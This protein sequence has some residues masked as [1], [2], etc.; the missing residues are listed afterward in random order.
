MELPGSNIKSVVGIADLRLKRERENDLRF[1]ANLLQ[2]LERENF[3]ERERERERE[4]TKYEKLIGRLE[5]V[6]VQLEALFAEFWTR[7]PLES[8][9]RVVMLKRLVGGIGVRV[10]IGV[11][12]I[13]MRQK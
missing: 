6:V 1:E 12:R 4:D 9:G 10:G 11:E 7:V 5:S 2:I 8:D 3:K 13:E